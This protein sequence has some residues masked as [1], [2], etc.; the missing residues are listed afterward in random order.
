MSYKEV[1]TPT[2]APGNVRMQIKAASICG[3]DI[4]RYVSG[5][6]EYPHDPGA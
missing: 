5:H 2:P 1:A 3:S 4:K 6:R